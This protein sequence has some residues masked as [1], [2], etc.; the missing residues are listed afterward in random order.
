MTHKRLLNLAYCGA[1]EIWVKENERLH[2]FPDNEYIQMR[3]RH[4]YAELE[5][6]RAELIKIEN[7]E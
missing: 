2:N 7:A 5:E 3:E 6:I 4:A 1:I